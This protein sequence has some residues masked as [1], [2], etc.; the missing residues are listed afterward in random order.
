MGDT[1]I[2]YSTDVMEDVRDRDIA[3]D[4]VVIPKQKKISR[5]QGKKI[6]LKKKK[7]KRL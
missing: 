5:W 2:S 4:S 3:L 7:K 1:V 6:T